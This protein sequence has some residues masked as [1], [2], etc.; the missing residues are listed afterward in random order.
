MEPIPANFAAGL[1]LKAARKSSGLSTQ[2]M[3]ETIFPARPFNS[4]AIT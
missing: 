4:M 3:F 1:Q 2:D